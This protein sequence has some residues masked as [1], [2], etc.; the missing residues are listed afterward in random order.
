MPGQH[1]IQYFIYLAGMSLAYMLLFK[2]LFDALK[3]TPPQQCGIITE[4]T[5][6]LGYLNSFEPYFLFVGLIVGT[7]WLIVKGINASERDVTR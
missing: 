4:C 1:I 7:L 3:A 2:P 5:D 6:T